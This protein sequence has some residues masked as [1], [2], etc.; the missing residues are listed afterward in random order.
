MTSKIYTYYD[1]ISVPRD[2]TDEQIIDSYQKLLEKYNPDIFEDNDK[3]QQVVK[4]LA[5]ITVAYDNLIDPIARTNHNKWIDQQDSNSLSEISK[6]IESVIGNVG[7]EIK[8]AASN[9]DLDAIGSEIKHI[10]ENAKNKISGIGDDLKGFA[11]NT[12]DKVDFD[13]ISENAQKKFSDIGDDLKDFTKNTGR[14][15]KSIK[16]KFYPFLKMSAYIVI[17]IVLLIIG[18]N[19]IKPDFN[20]PA[21][22]NTTSRDDIVFT[23]SDVDK[24]KNEITQGYL[25]ASKKNS[26][27]NFKSIMIKDPY[28]KRYQLGTVTTHTIK[29]KIVTFDHPVLA[30][31]YQISFVA[32]SIVNG[33]DLGAKSVTTPW[34]IDVIDTNGKLIGV[35]VGFSYD[36]NKTA[37][38]YI[39]Q[40]CDFK[41]L[42]QNQLNSID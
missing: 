20:L 8:N 35:D 42:T 3:K 41:P 21:I 15:I 26:D 6:S 39:P 40:D 36:D 29:D 13:G 19:T 33:Q 34:G 1:K 22:F 4:I 9:V 37:D 24:L 32:K 25:N 18:F 2:A 28:I 7:N 11:K 12:G 10:G 31:K 14:K 16:E 27:S 30:I 38:E 17:P 23:K 5:A